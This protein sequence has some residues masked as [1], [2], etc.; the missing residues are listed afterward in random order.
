MEKDRSARLIAIVALVLAVTGVSIGFA[1]L[2]T[3]LTIQAPV[4]NVNANKDLFKVYFSSSQSSYEHNQVTPSLSSGGDENFK[5][6]PID[7]SDTSTILSGIGGTFTAPGQTITY[8]L[9]IANVSKIKGYLTSIT[10]NNPDSGVSFAKCETVSDKG[11]GLEAESVATACQNLHV[12]VYV[13]GTKYSGS[14]SNISKNEI[15]AQVDAQPGMQ[16]LKVE[17]IYDADATPVDGDFKAT[18]GTIQLDY[19]TKDNTVI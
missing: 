18:F 5:G 6:N 8:E 10:F 7:I 17:I 13:N 15:N 3:N 19:E 9:G 1:V 4:A 14:N 11:N 12:N 2:S 16:T